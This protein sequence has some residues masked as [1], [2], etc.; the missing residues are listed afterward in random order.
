MSENNAHGY[1]TDSDNRTSH[2]LFGDLLVEVGDQV[3]A[4]FLMVTSIDMRVDSAR[5]ILMT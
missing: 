1:A 4:A 5:R 3:V 2:E